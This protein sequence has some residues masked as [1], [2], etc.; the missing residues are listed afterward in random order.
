M[1]LSSSVEPLGNLHDVVLFDLDGVIYIGPSAVD[2]A[3]EVLTTLREGDT[4]LGYITN[5]ASRP[6]VDIAEKLRAIGMPGVAD[7]DV[8][9]SAQA[10][11]R[12]IARRV[13]RGS[14]VLVVGGD[15]L[16]SALDEH[17]LIAVNSAKDD[18]AAVVQGFSPDLDWSLL[19]EGT[20]A[21]Q[22]DIPW[23]ASNVDLT[24][25]TPR[26]QAPANGSFVRLLARITGRRPIVAGKPE[27]PLFEESVVRTGGQRPLVVGDR[28][29]TDIRGARRAQIPSM[30]VLTGVT[31]LETLVRAEA[32]DRP[33][34]V[35]A[36]LRGLLQPHPDVRIRGDTADCGSVRVHHEFGTVKVPREPDDVTALLRATVALAWSYLD[37][38]GDALDLTEPLRA[39]SERMSP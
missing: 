20:F 3:A 22:A 33:D 7:D 36:D 17:G 26:G 14:R 39:L 21:I 28:L 24:F 35:A 2:H 29:D 16:R 19:S 25:P 6:P 13:P 8:V 23:F 31:D 32:G 5:N 37:R 27:R 38:G 34:Y 18:P 4:R 11:A 12:L 30:A 1:S 15:G 9:T 10:A